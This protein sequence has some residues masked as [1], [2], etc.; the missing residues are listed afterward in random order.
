MRYQT[1]RADPFCPLVDLESRYEHPI[2]LYRFNWIDYKSP[3]DLWV[4]LVILD[5]NEFHPVYLH[6]RAESV[7]IYDEKLIV[8]TLRTVKKRGKKMDMP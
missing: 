2:F 3:Y 5:S 7:T 8:D 6:S 4:I 1:S